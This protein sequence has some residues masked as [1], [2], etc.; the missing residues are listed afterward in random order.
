[1]IFVIYIYMGR[2]GT[3]FNKWDGEW[4]TFLNQWMTGRH[5]LQELAFFVVDGL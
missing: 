5:V 4:A 1:M 2:C 3:I